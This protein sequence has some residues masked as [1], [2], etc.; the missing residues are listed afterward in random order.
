MTNGPTWSTA[1]E[2]NGALL[3][4]GTDSYVS[5]PSAQA[6]KYTGGGLTLSTWVYVYATETTGA[7]L[8]SKPWNTYTGQYNYQLR[9]EANRTI[10]LYLQGNNST[11]YSLTTSAT[12]ATGVWHHVAVTVN[13]S[14]LVTIYVDGVSVASG[15]HS[16]TNWTPS[17]G[18]SS[19]PLVIGS[20]YPNSA[21]SYAADTL[22]GKL[23]NVRVYDQALT[24][25]AIQMLAIDPP[26]ATKS[27]SD[28]QHHRPGGRRGVH[29]PGQHHHQCQCR[30]RRWADCEG[31]LLRGRHV[32]GHRYHGPVFLDVEER[33]AGRPQFD[34]GG[35]RQ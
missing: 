5:V 9:L 17:G 10:S 28:R 33:A 21:G 11:P 15:T 18:D 6:L 3:F 13:S 35:Y 30:R 4:D 25:A 22:D 20:K 7:D 26:A 29:Q 23:D 1:G 2:F 24:S 14:R 27:G 32:A 8:L 34:G 31:G 12:I 16:I 19:K